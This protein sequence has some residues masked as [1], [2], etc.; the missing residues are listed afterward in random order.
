MRV[1]SSTNLGFTRAWSKVGDG[2]P[3][4]PGAVGGG[5]GW[6]CRRVAGGSI[7]IGLVMGC[8]AGGGCGW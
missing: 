8:D 4:E 7:M 5:A 6:L 3:P 2:K 1:T